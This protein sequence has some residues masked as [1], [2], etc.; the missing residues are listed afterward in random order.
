MKVMTEQER[1][2]YNGSVMVQ[3]SAIRN[4]K[5]RGPGAFCMVDRQTGKSL[6]Y[7]EFFDIHAMTMMVI[8]EVEDRHALNSN[9][10]TLDT[11]NNKE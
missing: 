5:E 2:W 11:L 6:T 9:P 3:Q 4:M 1:Q 7:A 10:K 8:K